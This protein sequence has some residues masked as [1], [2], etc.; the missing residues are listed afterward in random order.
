MNTTTIWIMQGILATIMSTSG[1]IILV[2]PKRFL[3]DRLS[4]V[5]TFPNGMR[6]FICLA[7]IAGALGLILPML[8]NI[9][10]IITAFAAIGIA[11]LMIAAFVYHLQ[12]KEYKDVPATILF[13]IIA[14]LIS[15]YRF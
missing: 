11:F 3:E 6:I 10:P 15:Y 14:L 2:L 13:L 9:V 8:L 4:W 7:K 1:I 12:T 5:K